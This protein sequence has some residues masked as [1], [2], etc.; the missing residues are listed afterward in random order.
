[1]RDAGPA[2]GVLNQA[3]NDPEAVALVLFGSAASGPTHEGLISA[4]VDMNRYLV[5]L[6]VIDRLLCPIVRS[7]H[8]VNGT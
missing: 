1:M 7:W 8:S 6:R 4:L 5:S 2:R 3:L